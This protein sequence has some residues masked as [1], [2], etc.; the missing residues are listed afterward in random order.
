MN[1]DT[2]GRALRIRRAH[3]GLDQNEAA[4]QIG[5]S[6]T[7]Y[8]AYE[9]DAQR[10]SVDVLP[11]IAG[12]LGVSIDDVLAL[13]G[14]SAILTARTALER[15]GTAGAEPTPS[16]EL[17]AESTTPESESASTNGHVSADEVDSPAPEE[18]SENP[19]TVVSRAALRI[20]EDEEKQKGK[21]KKKKKGKREKSALP[22]FVA[23][24]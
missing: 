13:Y 2:V 9:R 22:A 21:K 20:P 23:H 19:P 3:L 5:T 11:A 15:L 12:F 1:D 14:A 18:F 7:T 24:V 6:R 16:V 8:S 4:I 10:P 17:V